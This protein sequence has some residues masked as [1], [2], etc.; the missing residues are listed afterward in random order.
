MQADQ[1]S[2]NPLT[3]KALTPFKYM[4]NFTYLLGLLSL[5]WV[6]I[7]QA[8][9]SLHP[10]LVSFVLCCI[11]KHPEQCWTR[12]SAFPNVDTWLRFVK[13]SSWCFSSRQLCSLA[14]CLSSQP[15]SLRSVSGHAE[16]FRPSLI[17]SRSQREVLLA[18]L[19][20][21]Y[22]KSRTPCMHVCWKP[23]LYIEWGKKSRHTLWSM[24]WLS[25]RGVNWW[26]GTG[27]DESPGM[28]TVPPGPIKCD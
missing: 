13:G 17:Y 12:H 5:Y 19:Y 3:C 18:L 4:H 7:S 21:L 26:A 10:L 9:P 16:S 1:C 25:F 6:K 24:H 8:P 2:P 23:T 22:Q 14:G 27:M 11:P 20:C 28:V 15:T